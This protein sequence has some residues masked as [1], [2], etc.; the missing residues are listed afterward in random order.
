M[1]SAQMPQRVLLILHKA[2]VLSVIDYG[3]GL[4]TLSTAQLKR[5]ETIQNEEMR[6][7]LG[8]SK[9][10]PVEAMRYI[11]ELPPMEDR[12]KLAWLRSRLTLVL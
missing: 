7:I 5:L 6:S 3:F 10:T 1:A 8:C 12:H 11:L 9:D 2:L 4:L